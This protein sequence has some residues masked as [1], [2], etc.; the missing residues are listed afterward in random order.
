MEKT[1]QS[2]FQLGFDDYLK[3]HHIPF[4]YHQAA[5]L[6]MACRTAVLGGHSQYCENN[7]L[8]GVWYN[9]CKH[10][11]CPQCQGLVQ[12]RWL[13]N[14]KE[15]LLNCQHA[16]LVF[17]I[18]HEYLDYWRYNS[19]IMT[20]LLFTCAKECLNDLL[21]DDPEK[22]YLDAQPGFIM[23][24]H[25]SGRDLSLH[26][27][28]HCIITDGGLT[29]TGNWVKPKRSV[30]LPARVLMAKFRGKFN[31]FIREQAKQ[32]NWIYPSGKNYQQLVNLTNIL[33]RKKWNVYIKEHFKYAGK[34]LKYLVNYLKGGVLKNAQITNINEK[35]VTFC[36]YP[37]K[38]NP[39]GKK[40]N[41]CSRTLT[42]SELID[43]YCQHIPKP[44]TITVR[45]YGI[46]SNGNRAKLNQAR[47]HLKQE[48]IAPATE[49]KKISWRDYLANIPNALSQTL[50]KKC[51]LPINIQKALPRIS[52]A[53]LLLEANAPP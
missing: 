49:R 52:L 15:K 5:R 30:I 48:L 9:S 35:T 1:L 18:P 51:Q 34:L 29:E 3:T 28:I 50:C 40:E 26:P 25:T 47:E 42:H 36:Y 53:Q 44:G 11:S 12:F 32:D 22:K 7:H 8:N 10:R 37:H 31:A 43:L 41:S 20:G 38:E 46:Y 45:H 39:D 19:D 24:L 27:H 33:G 4:Y 21:K 2:V 14:Q 16:H 17:T 23:A 13:E 6:I